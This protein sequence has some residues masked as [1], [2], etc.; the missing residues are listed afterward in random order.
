ML[1]ARL[2][3]S[4]SYPFLWAYTLSSSA[5]PIP[6]SALLHSTPPHTLFRIPCTKYSIAVY[7]CC[8]NICT[9]MLGVLFIQR[10]LEVYLPC[11]RQ[12]GTHR[13]PPCLNRSV[14]QTNINIFSTVKSLAGEARLLRFNLDYVRLQLYLTPFNVF[15]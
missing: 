3:S 8:V 13:V 2:R 7:D 11:L 9:E 15:I 1:R 4:G 12:Q 14:H 5:T 6:L 10:G